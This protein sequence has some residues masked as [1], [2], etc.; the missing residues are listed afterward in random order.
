[1]RNE[2]IFTQIMCSNNSSTRY[3]VCCSE[4]DYCNDL[5]AFSQDIRETL[6]PSRRGKTDQVDIA[7]KN[8]AI[9]FYFLDKPIRMIDWKILTMIIVATT[10]I[11]FSIIIALLYLY[12]RHGKRHKSREMDYGKG[13]FYN[14]QGSTSVHSCLQRIFRSCFPME[15]DDGRIPSDQSLTGL[16]DD[17]SSSSTG[18]GWLKM[19]HSV[20]WYER[21]FCS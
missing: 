3:I 1:M 19:R 12:L 13:T 17:L 16:L 4:R 14:D 2:Y 5:D 18:P 9:V 6:L 7:K 20:Q 15:Q 10:L 11:C 21:C 8:T